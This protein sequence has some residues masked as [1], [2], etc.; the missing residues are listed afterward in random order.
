MR[1][2]KMILAVF[3][4]SYVFVF[5]STAFADAVSEWS[6]FENNLRKGKISSAE[7]K[8]LAD[9]LVPKL[10]KEISEK[11]VKEAPQWVF[12]VA[13]FKTSNVSNAK[14]IL[15]S[16][17]ES[18]SEPKFLEGL[19]FLVQPYIR[20]AIST[21]TAA[22]DTADVVA[23]NDGVVVYVKKGAMNSPGGNTVWLYNPEQNFF[24]YYGTLKNISVN[25]GDVVAAGDKIGNIKS[26]KKGYVI[27]FA[28]LVYGD[29]EFTIF[30]YFDEME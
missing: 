1:K 12:P 28:V 19:E 10:N 9:K 13:G 16:M 29:G 17:S 27:N 18:V 21:K 6:D 5:A 3:F 25:L 8:F 2:N 24:I 23:A 7:G 26:S 30:N 20:V 4:I 15:N 22:K 11:G 14:K